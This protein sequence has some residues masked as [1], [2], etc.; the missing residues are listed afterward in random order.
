APWMARPSP[1]GWV[2]GVF[3]PHS[4]LRRFKD[5][6]RLLV[7]PGSRE[8]KIKFKFKFKFKF[9]GKSRSRNSWLLLLLL[10]LLPPWV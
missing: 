8:K 5:R 6:Q 10:P 1:H 9:K 3:C 2:Y 4:A 7:P